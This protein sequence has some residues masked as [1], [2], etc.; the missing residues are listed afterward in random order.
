MGRELRSPS[1]LLCLISVYLI[2]LHL[3][4][5]VRVFVCLVNVSINLHCEGHG[6][7]EVFLLHY[8]ISVSV[9]W[10]RTEGG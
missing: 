7:L 8:F 4:S 6:G 2:V 1:T 3:A 10:P 5:H 9:V